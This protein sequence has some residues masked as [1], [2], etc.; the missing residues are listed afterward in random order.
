MDKTV[1]IDSRRCIVG[2]PELKP[3]TDEKGLFWW[4]I[5]VPLTIDSTL[6]ARGACTAIDELKKNGVGQ[7]VR[8]VTPG[9]PGMDCTIGYAQ[10]DPPI[11][12]PAGPPSYKFVVKAFKQS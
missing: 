2:S 7:D 4:Q 3:F 12:E 11:Q 5:T 6:V 1:V 9:C 10:F 8:V